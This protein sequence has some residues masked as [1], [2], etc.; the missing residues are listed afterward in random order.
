MADGVRSA[1]QKSGLDDTISN[2]A[3]AMMG[4]IA[5]QLKST[6]NQS[7]P[8][9]VDKLQTAQK[10]DGTVIDKSKAATSDT[11]NTPTASSVL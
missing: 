10:T 5:D 6:L 7:F 9:F 1:I 3:A 8:G 2:A 11:G 4:S